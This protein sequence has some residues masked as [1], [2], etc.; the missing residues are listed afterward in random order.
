MHPVN[1]YVYLCILS[2]TQIHRF[3]L[4]R[5]DEKLIGWDKASSS[6]DVTMHWIL[7][8]AVYI[9][10]TN[11]AAWGTWD[12]ILELY[13]LSIGIAELWMNPSWQ[14]RLFLGNLLF[15]RPSRQ[16]PSML[17]KCCNKILLHGTF[18]T[19]GKPQRLVRISAQPCLPYTKIKI[20]LCIWYSLWA[21]QLKMPLS[22]YNV[23]GSHE[24]T[25][26]V[27]ATTVAEVGEMVEGVGISEAP[28]TPGTLVW[29]HKDYSINVSDDK[30]PHR[31]SK[32]VRKWL[33]RPNNTICANFICLLVLLGFHAKQIKFWR[34]FLGDRRWRCH[35][36]ATQIWGTGGF[37][38]RPCYTRLCTEYSPCG[39]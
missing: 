27:R 38:C 28:A 24:A 6:D 23:S 21:V 33:V 12:V 22:P 3:R 26:G 1:L 2:K 11:I 14:S 17:H 31:C 4:T 32:V 37:F 19:G 35:S 34:S 9:V 5:G 13:S 16:Y 10:N 25:R 30:F 7:C 29:G 8:C 39:S 18:K 15:D 36:L 20:F